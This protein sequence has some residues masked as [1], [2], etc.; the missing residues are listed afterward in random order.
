MTFLEFLSPLKR[1]KWLFL[2]LWAGLSVGL[3]FFAGFL[4][5]IQK[6]T[7]F[8]TVKP[9]AVEGKSFVNDG[10]E[11]AECVA[12]MI[13]GWAKDPNF[14]QAIQDEAGIK[15][16]KLKKKISAKKQNRLNVFWTL[17]LWGAEAKNSRKLAESLSNVLT[18]TLARINQDS[19]VPVHITDP[20]IF[21]EPLEIPKSWIWATA[22]ILA[23]FFAGFYIYN[24]ESWRGKVSFLPQVKEVFHKTPIFQVAGKIKSHDKRQIDLFL[25]SFQSPRLIST[26]PQ[27][28]KFFEIYN[29]N[30][31]V[32]LD[33]PILLVKLGETTIRELENNRAIFGRNVGIIVFEG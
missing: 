16:P 15:V 31:L 33:T 18:E 27:A 32:E 23:L 26:F 1:K 28:G 14:L 13:A 21:I 9:V 11:S 20:Q 10:V 3:Y 25:R 30:S 6:T 17:K 22:I 29:P 4:P 19:A 5:Q 7:I 24:A 8:F 2:A 12:E